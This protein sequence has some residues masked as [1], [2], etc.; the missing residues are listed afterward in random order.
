MAAAGAGVA[1]LPAIFADRC[2]AAGVRQIMVRDS[3]LRGAV[4]AM[5]R[6]KSKLP[7]EIERLIGLI[8]GAAPFAR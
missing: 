7:V 8:R 1:V 6:K 2:Q 4:C 3:G 5:W